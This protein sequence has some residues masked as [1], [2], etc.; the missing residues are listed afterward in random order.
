MAVGKGG[1]R[2]ALSPKTSTLGAT[3]SSLSF[4]IGE[5]QLSRQGTS[6]TNAGNAQ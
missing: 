2:L 3:L 4:L 6:A 1:S 5:L